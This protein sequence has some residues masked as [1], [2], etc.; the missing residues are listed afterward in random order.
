M[1]GSRAKKIRKETIKTIEK[2]GKSLRH[3]R[4]YYKKAKKMY[5]R[6]EL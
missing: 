1:S 3:F 4:F 5:L 6:G 2:L